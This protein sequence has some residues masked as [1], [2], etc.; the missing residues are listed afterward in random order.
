MCVSSTPSDHFCLSTH[1]ACTHSI[2]GLRYRWRKHCVVWSSQQ[3]TR[4]QTRL[5]KTLIVSSFA[6]FPPIISCR[7]V[8]LRTVLLIWLLIEQ[9]LCK[10]DFEWP[11]VASLPHLP[12]SPR[13]RGWGGRASTESGLQLTSKSQLTFQLGLYVTVR[14][15]RRSLD[16]DFVGLI[17]LMPVRMIWL[18]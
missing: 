13:G 8:I 11:N 2:R 18:V 10:R 17:L 4:G 5:M 1:T 7:N 16:V 6:C 3:G 14:W 15:W 12:T 9:Q